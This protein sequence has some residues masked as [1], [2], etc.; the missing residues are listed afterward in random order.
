MTHASVVS[1]AGSAADM[2]VKEAK[3]QAAQ[4]QLGKVRLEEQELQNSLPLKTLRVLQAVD[5]DPTVPVKHRV[6]LAWSRLRELN[7]I[8]TDARLPSRLRIRLWK[9][10]VVP[11]LLYGCER[12]KLTQTVRRKLN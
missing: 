9:S 12:W 5:G 1:R 2:L 4:D 6:T 3:T 7:R 10:S 8:L 11:T